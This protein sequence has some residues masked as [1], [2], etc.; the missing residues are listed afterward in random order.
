MSAKIVEM[1]A[2]SGRFRLINESVF[3]DLRCLSAIVNGL[4]VAERQTD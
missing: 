4:N 3:T 1:I 2:R